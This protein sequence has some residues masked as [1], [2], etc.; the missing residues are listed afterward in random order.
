MRF[1]VRQAAAV[2]ALAAIWAA[3]PTAPAVAQD[4]EWEGTLDRGDVVTVRGVNGSVSARAASGNQLRITATKEADGDDPATVRIEVIEDARGV[5]ACAV[6]PS[7]QGREPNRCGRDDDYRMRVNDNDVKVHF[8]VEVPEGLELDARTVNGHIEARGIRGGMEART[9]NG[10]IEVEAG[11]P[12]S[13]ETVNGSISA[14]MDRRPSEGLRFKTVNGAIELTLPNGTAADLELRTVNGSIDTEFPLTI[15]GR[16]GP[17]SAAGEIGGG[18]P[19]IE[20][21]TVNG[22]IA[23]I[24]GR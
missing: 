4:F 15:R 21:P 9:V 19:E 2:A 14:L 12:V 7:R 10:A 11:G 3:A 6:Y 1:S 16:W 5:I 17:K 24:R 20:L 18:G 23:L 22:S 13:A 8:I